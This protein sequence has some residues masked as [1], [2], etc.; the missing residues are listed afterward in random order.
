VVLEDG[1]VLNEGD[2]QVRVQ[3]YAIAYR[4]LV[5]RASECENLYATVCMS[6]SHVAYGTIRMEPVYMILGQA[7]GIGASLAVDE[8]TPVQ[9]VDL[10]KLRAKL[11]QGKAVLSPDEIRAAGAIPPGPG[12][13]V[14]DADA[15]KTGEW[16]L[17]TSTPPFVGQ[18]YVHDGNSDRGKK[19]IRFSPRLPQAGSYE[20][21]LIY[22]PHANRASNALVVVHSEDGESSV[23]VDQRKSSTPLGTFRF[24]PAGGWVELRNDGADGYV[25]A[26]A[27]RFT[28]S[29]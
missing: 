5:P 16:T 25:V 23:R 18:G 17:S 22:P 1:T 11:L 2:F 20:V 9:K 13:V 27:V 12:I 4:S 19:S 7:A 28:L 15:V 29:K 26:D 10:R 24:A 14:D 8:R 6:A 21:I 3:P